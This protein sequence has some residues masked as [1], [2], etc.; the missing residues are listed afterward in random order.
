MLPFT[1][2]L[3][4][5]PDDGLEPVRD[6]IESAETSLLI[7]QFT[8]TEESL[9]G[10]VIG[11][12]QA[13]VDVRV[14][15]NPQR[16]GG[17]RANDDTF[18]TLSTAGVKVA[19]SSP[20][21]YVTHEKSIVADNKAALVAT[22]NLCEKYFTRTRDY[23][24]ITAVPSH[25]RQIVEVFEADW[26]HRDWVPSVFE[27]L[28]WSNANSRYHMAEFIDAAEQRL[29]IQHP[30]YVDAV[31]L[32]RVAAAVDR[33]VRVRVLCG[34]R[35]GISEWDILDTFASLRTLRRIGVKVHKQKNL[36]VHA[37]LLVV[38]NAHAL[39]GSM[40]IDRSAFDLRREL[41]ITITDE[42]VVARL[43][44][45]FNTDWDLSHQYDPPDP[46]DSYQHQEDDFPHDPELMHE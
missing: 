24:V 7:K 22:F 13:G 12:C 16:S 40:N 32:D 15:L 31:I 28:L 4:V 38:D 5:E 35:H 36:R 37:K 8:F 45:V 2:R 20:K 30:K 34:G 26:E 33:G 46:L 3:I 6:F 10:A 42:L 21:F 9:I 25:V 27:G 39:V 19:W 14:M 18:E 44:D 17:D 1:P 11:R 29:D 43:Q 23:G 41:G